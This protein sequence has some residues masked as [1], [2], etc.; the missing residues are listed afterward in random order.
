MR[1]LFFIDRGFGGL[2]VMR[3]ARLDLNETERLPFPANQV[4]FSLSAP[5][6]PVARD[7]RVTLL[8]QIEVREVFATVAGDEVLWTIAGHGRKAIETAEQRFE[9]TP[10]HVRGI[11]GRWL[12]PCSRKA[13]RRV[14]TQFSSGNQVR[15]AWMTFTV[16]TSWPTCRCV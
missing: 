6:P 9:R 4:E 13:R 1:P 5:D 8:T 7:D 11:L 10:E 14:R 15:R 16:V 3:G 12:M 2:Y